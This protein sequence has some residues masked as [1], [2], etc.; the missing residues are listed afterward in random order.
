MYSINS[1][2]GGG[3]G[4]YIP[5]VSSSASSGG[6]HRQQAKSGV[7]VK[8][9]RKNEH[10]VRASPTLSIASSVHSR[11][12]SIN[13]SQ[14]A[15]ASPQSS[16]SSPSTA[17]AVEQGPAPSP[18]SATKSLGSPNAGYTLH[19]TS[20]A[21]HFFTFGRCSTTV[22]ALLA[23]CL[24]AATFLSHFPTGSEAQAINS[25]IDNTDGPSHLFTGASL[26]GQWDLIGHSGVSAMHAILRPFTE[27]V[28]FLERVQSSTFA[29]AK[30][31]SAV[32]GNGGN[33][34]AW[35]TEFS[36]KDG[37]WRSLDVK[38]NMFCSAGGY[39]PD[40]V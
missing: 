3:S 32:G 15:I 34:F 4:N 18:R 37:E 2:D 36:P 29:K 7:K 17:E 26:G 38:S 10:G 31:S 23:T 28:L 39:L 40:G 25:H 13:H 9:G 11:S 16:T 8:T 33:K 1:H 5:L 35:S 20:N 19:S 24:L 27:S 21:R 6:H 30:G 12:S 22:P 14:F